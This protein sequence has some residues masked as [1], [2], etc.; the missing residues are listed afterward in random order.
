M[1]RIVTDSSSDLPQ[2][3]IDE[4]AIEVV[5]LTIRFG[6]EHFVDRVELGVAE[7]WDRLTSGA[8]LPETA[9]PSA[10]SFLESYRRLADEG[11]GGIVAICIS[12]AMSATYQAA[13]IAAERASDLVPVRVIDSA[14]VSMALGF[15]V[16]AA[17]EA[18]RDGTGLDETVAAAM[19]ARESTNVF[20]ALDTLEFL[21]R[22]GRIGGAAALIG[23][24][25]DVKPLITLGDGTV[26]A[27]GRVR[28]RGRALAAVAAEV[29]KLAPRLRDVAVL[30]GATPDLDRLVETVKA[31]APGIE[32]ITA[33]LGP[34]VGTHTGPGVAGVAYRLG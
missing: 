8:R 1:I 17:A 11:A 7:F 18:A 31:A 25:L 3:L 30:H 32:P 34:V 16:V 26:Q 9:A 15:Q 22:G 10:G 21:R 24:F 12:S 5:P 28:T 27:A 23:G 33:E 29:E 2:D 4:H 13:V 20:A 6:D 14:A 19:A